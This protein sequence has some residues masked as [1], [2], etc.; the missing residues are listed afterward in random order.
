M[1][2]FYWLKLK[3]DFFD[4]DEIRLIERQ[5][6]GSQYIVFWLRLLLKAISAEEPGILIFKPGIPYTAEILAATTQTDIDIVRSAMRVFQELGMIQIG[7]DNEIFLNITGLVGSEGDSAERV[8]KF[9]ARE[10]QA[11]IEDKTGQ[12]LQCNKI[13]TES[14]RKSKRKRGEGEKEGETEEPPPFFP[15]DEIPPSIQK[16]R[17][18]GKAIYK[19]FDIAPILDDLLMFDEKYGYGTCLK[20]WH[21][22]YLPKKRDKLNFFATDF[23]K[24]MD[25]IEPELQDSEAIRRVR[26]REKSP[27][28]RKRDQQVLSSL[29]YTFDEAGKPIP[30]GQGEKK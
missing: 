4:S 20:I 11:Q 1:R 6:N 27:E 12:A 3:T 19:N 21:E 28:E 8:R 5:E 7:D 18:E 13:V 15:D 23:L 17:T 14:K 16:I 24:V 10:K 22:Y 25:R 30:P 26:E 2:R 29:G 9:R